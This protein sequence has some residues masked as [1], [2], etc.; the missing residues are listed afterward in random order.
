MNKNKLPILKIND[1][2]ETPFKAFNM[3]TCFNDFLTNKTIWDP[4]VCETEL[5]GKRIKECLPTIKEV[6]HDKKFNL[7]KNQNPDFDIII[8]NPP[9]SN[10]KNIWRELLLLKK[11]FCLL[12]PLSF[13]GCKYFIDQLEI[14]QN[15]ITVL[16]PQQRINY[17]PINQ[18]SKTSASPFHSV[19]V[20]FQMNQPSLQQF[21]EIPFYFSQ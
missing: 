4:F 10:K 8:T 2:Y 1:E 13:L 21:I 20:C 6:I 14:N 12:V 16:F 3:L 9:F 17:I 5:A 7:M 19:W 11:P 18:N 15:D